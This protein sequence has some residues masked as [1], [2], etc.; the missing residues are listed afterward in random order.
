[1]W[2]C[3]IPQK[4]KKKKLYKTFQNTIWRKRDSKER[5]VEV[6]TGNE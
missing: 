2:S 3:Y 6:L 1:M 5:V 4:G